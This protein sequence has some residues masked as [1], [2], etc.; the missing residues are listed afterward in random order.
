MSLR[1]YNPNTNQTATVNSDKADA[2]GNVWV[3][4]DGQMPVK[5]NWEEFLKEFNG[6]GINFNKCYGEIK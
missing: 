5:I 1:Y 2:D 3:E 4:I 6:L